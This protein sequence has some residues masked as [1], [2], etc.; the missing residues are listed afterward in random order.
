M[1]AIFVE[2][3]R[4]NSDGHLLHLHVLMAYRATIHKITKCTPNLVMRGKEVPLPTNI[5]A[6]FPQN[7]QLL[8]NRLLAYV[9][10]V[11]SVL[12]MSFSTLQKNLNSRFRKK[13]IVLGL[14]FLKLRAFSVGDMLWRWYQPKANK[15]LG[16]GWI[17]PFLVSANYLTYH[18]KINVWT[19]KR[20]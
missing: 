4:S 20:L 10:W 12:E 5:A 19:Q 8:T 17:G 15:K 9:K 18:M 13:N 7:N 1:Q 14:T 2:E 3:N 6:G 16:L 11:R